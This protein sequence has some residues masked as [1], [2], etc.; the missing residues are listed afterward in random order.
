MNDF[1]PTD[2]QAQARAKEDVTER[3]K[4]AAVD[5]GNDFKWLMSNKRGRRIIWRLLEKTG[6]FRTSFTG[7]NATFFNEGQRNIGLMLI[8]DI[9]EYCPE[10]YLT[11][12]KERAN[13]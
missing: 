10:M 7:D 12:L 5:A 2:I 4:L 1:D 3:A 9:H 13:G 11:M 6:V 8:S